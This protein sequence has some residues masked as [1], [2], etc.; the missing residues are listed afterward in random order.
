N[1]TGDRYVI[2][3]NIEGNELV[4]IK[5]LTINTISRIDMEFDLSE[6]SDADIEEWLAAHASASTSLRIILSGLRS[7]ALPL[8]QIESYKDRYYRIDTQDRTR[9][10]LDLM[11]GELRHENSLRGEFF[12]IL[13]NRI[14]N[15]EIPPDIDPLI[16][17]D[18]LE[19]IIRSKNPAAEEQLCALFSA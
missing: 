2:S 15:G 19:Q 3:L 14:K 17:S 13:G 16:L 4:K 12:S 8:K 10:P 18:L 7:H 5:R 1:E 11:C 6:S 9:A